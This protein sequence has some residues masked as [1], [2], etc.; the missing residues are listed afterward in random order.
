MLSLL[1]PLQFWA[2]SNFELIVLAQPSEKS[3][4]SSVQCGTYLNVINVQPSTD[5]YTP[6]PLR[7]VPR[8]ANI[9]RSVFTLLLCEIFSLLWKDNTRYAFLQLDDR[10]LV[11]RGA[12][13]P[14]MS[15]IN[16]ESDVWQHIKVRL[17]SLVVT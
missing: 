11:Y 8:R 12:D 15:V 7:R 16:P 14:D 13:Q 17:F 1:T 10:A 6:S 2:P 3:L 9:L 5:S 4:P